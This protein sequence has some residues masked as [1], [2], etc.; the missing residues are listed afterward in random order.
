MPVTSPPVTVASETGA[1]YTAAT[2]A[3]CL[4][5]AASA[6]GGT[7]A[8]LGGAGG[9]L[10]AGTVAGGAAATA[11]GAAASAAGVSAEAAGDDITGAV[12]AAGDA[13][14]RRTPSL[15]TANR[16]RS[17][18]PTCATAPGRSS[19][20][21][22]LSTVATSTAPS[23]TCTEAPAAVTPTEKVVPLT[24]A[25]RY[26]VFTSKCGVIFFLIMKTTLPKSSNSCVKPF[27]CCASGRRSR[28]LAATIRYSLPRTRTAR[29]PGP[30]ETVSPAEMPIPRVATLLVPARAICT[31]P[32]ISLTI[33]PGSPATAAEEQ[34]A[35]SIAT[36][37]FRMP[38]PFDFI[39]PD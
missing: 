25:A 14:T 32:L 37:A 27:A 3:A 34:L 30:V 13:I 19:S 10:G 18:A 39:T 17:F 2:I 20:C 28:E 24:T 35:A 5:T 15:S 11:A 9:A 23:S 26:G 29:P 12:G 7:T 21:A 36:N 22:P 31:D 33:Q 16:Y 1:S 8:A 4:G 6:L 38:N